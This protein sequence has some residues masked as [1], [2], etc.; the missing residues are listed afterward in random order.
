MQCASAATRTLGFALLCCHPSART[1]DQS[2]SFPSAHSNIIRLVDHTRE[3]CLV[4]FGHC[5]KSSSR[6][7][8]SFGRPRPFTSMRLGVSFPDSGCRENADCSHCIGK[9]RFCCHLSTECKN[10]LLKL[11]PWSS[12][13]LLTM[14]FRKC[15]SCV[16][17]HA[18]STRNRGPANFPVHQTS[19]QLKALGQLS[20]TT[21]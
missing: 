20:T 1:R 9:S 10:F 4:C 16:L 13:S 11:S 15:S 19:S 2:L 17:S 14:R 7:V 8:N 12:T 5:W 3:E 18:R 21:R 6:R